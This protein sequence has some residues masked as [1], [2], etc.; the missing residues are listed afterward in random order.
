MCLQ[1]EDDDDDDDVDIP[2]FQNQ[3]STQGSLQHIIQK[4]Q[5]KIT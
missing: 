2:P 4:Y 1:S 5:V 3:S